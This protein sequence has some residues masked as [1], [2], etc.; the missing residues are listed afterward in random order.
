MNAK[1]EEHSL[2]EAFIHQMI[3]TIEFFLG[4][5]SNTASYLRLWALSLAH[6]KLAETF[7]LLTL[8]KVMGM[9]PTGVF[10]STSTIWTIVAST[11]VWPM[12]WSVTLCLIVLM[13]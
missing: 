6:S 9:L 8:I 10:T 2:A 1:E 12:F 5:I 13:T 3:E 11:V 7:M 4:A